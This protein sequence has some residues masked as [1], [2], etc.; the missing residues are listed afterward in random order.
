M[1]S[2]Q[3]QE[4][5]P[6][7]GGSPATSS[8]KQHW[9]P[10]AA[11]AMLVLGLMLFQQFKPPAPGTRSP[12]P[13]G[14]VKEWRSQ[15]EPRV[16]PLAGQVVLLGLNT[17]VQVLEQSESKVRLLLVEGDLRVQ[18]QRPTISVETSRL[19]VVA[20]SRDFGVATNE[21]RSYVKALAGQLKVLDSASGKVTA[22]D[23]EQSLQIPPPPPLK[24]APPS[25]AVPAR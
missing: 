6:L 16:I 3:S 5:Q 15:K 20:P 22:L 24:S 14:A 25:S 2:N 18:Q 21:H 4:N 10:L 9:A 12:A 8:G 11:A 23:P 19:K 17:H 13:G 1:E 7:D